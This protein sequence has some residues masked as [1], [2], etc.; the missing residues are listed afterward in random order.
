MIKTKRPTKFIQHDIARGQQ[1]VNAVFMF[2]RGPAKVRILIRSDS[3]DFQSYARAE[4]LS[5]SDLKWNTAAHIPFAEMQTP[6]KLYYRVGPIAVETFNA[7]FDK[8]LGI[9]DGLI[10]FAPKASSK[11]AV[12]LFF[13]DAPEGTSVEDALIGPKFFNNEQ[14]AL[15]RFAEYFVPRTRDMEEMYEPLAISLGL[16]E[17]DNISE[18]IAKIPDSMLIK[19]VM[20]GKREHLMKLCDSYVSHQAMVGGQAFYRIEPV[21]A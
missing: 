2:E 4:V 12:V 6:H 15:Q 9:V 20:A 1:D 16:D 14:A 5:P 11:P 10:G 13:A 3:Y 7:D 8:L 18:T 19:M 17:K 21:P